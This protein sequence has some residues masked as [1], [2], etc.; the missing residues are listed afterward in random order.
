M[1][2]NPWLEFYEEVPPV[3][4]PNPEEGDYYFSFNEFNPTIYD[5]GTWEPETGNFYNGAYGFGGWECDSY[6]DLSGYKYIVA[7][8]SEPQAMDTSFLVYDSQNYW[9]PSYKESFGKD[10]L[11]IGELSTMT[12]PINADKTVSEYIDPSHIYRVGFLN[13]GGKTPI[14]IKRVYVT[15]DD[16]YN[17]WYIINSDL[18]NDCAIYN[19]QGMRISEDKD[20]VNSLPVGVYIVNGKKIF[21]R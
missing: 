1:S 20:C 11:I 9:G 21:V 6:Y 17:S 3:I 8:L 14:K 15:N 10:T 5:I 2:K 12:K 18:S 19:L 13:W 4:R 16:P 7:E